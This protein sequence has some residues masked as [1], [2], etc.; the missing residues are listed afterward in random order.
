VYLLDTD[1]CVYVLNERSAALATRFRGIAPTELAT[2]IINIAELRYGMAHSQRPV[3]NARRLE[4]LLS[5]LTVLPFDDRAAFH[6][7][8]LKHALASRGTLIGPMD[9]LIAAIA[10][11]H[12][13]TLVTNNI[14]EFSRVPGLRTENWL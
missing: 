9:L 8:E 13:A 7:A 6:F 4:S 5:P 3:Q 2:S 11:A 12:D 10:L 1:I 14:G